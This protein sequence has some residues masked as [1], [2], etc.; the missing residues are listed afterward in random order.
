[1]FRKFFYW[2]FFKV[3]IVFI[4]FLKKILVLFYFIFSYLFF[5]FFRKRKNL[6]KIFNKNFYL[7]NFVFLFNSIF[8]PINIIFKKLFEKRF[9]ELIENK[10]LFQFLFNTKFYLLENKVTLFFLILFLIRFIFLY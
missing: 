8:Y 3:E 9:L 10:V 6:I 5:K 7:D 1:M 4:S 2:N